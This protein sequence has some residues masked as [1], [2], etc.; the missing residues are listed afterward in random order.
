MYELNQ[1]HLLVHEQ[2]QRELHR[3]ANRQRLARDA[4]RGGR[5]KSRTSTF[6]R[7]VSLFL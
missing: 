3:E 6:A 1:N 4:R 2:R 7:L 5:G